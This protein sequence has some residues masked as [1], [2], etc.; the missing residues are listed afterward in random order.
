MEILVNLLLEGFF[1]RW[2]R[3]TSHPIKKGL[4]ISIAVLGGVM[5]AAIFYKIRTN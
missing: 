2:F 1:L 4:I 5:V 3:N